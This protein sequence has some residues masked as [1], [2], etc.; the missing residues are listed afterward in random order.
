MVGLK[1]AGGNDDPIVVKLATV[2]VVGRIT[3]RTPEELIVCANEATVLRVND[4]VV[5]S[6]EV[7]KLILVDRF[8]VCTK[9]SVFDA[10]DK[11]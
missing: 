9:L 10:A 1:E 4:M 11:L 8:N 2:L 7:G 3:D 5:L 6:W